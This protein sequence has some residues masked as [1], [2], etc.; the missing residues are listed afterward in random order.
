MSQTDA[1]LD[2]VTAAIGDTPLIELARITAN[3]D[4][5]ILAKLEYL[6]PGLSKKDRAALCVTSMSAPI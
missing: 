4:G 5:R 3:V 1:L 6:N 2:S